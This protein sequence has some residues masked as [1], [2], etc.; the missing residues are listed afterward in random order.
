MGTFYALVMKQEIWNQGNYDPADELIN[1]NFDDY[2]SAMPEEVSVIEGF[3]EFVAMYR[4]GFSDTH[5]LV[6]HQVA[7]GA[8]W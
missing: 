3:K 5:I 6:E 7:E 2:D 1:P 4:S 8:R